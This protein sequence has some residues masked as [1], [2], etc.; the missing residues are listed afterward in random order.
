MT[1]RQRRH[2]S[3]APPARHRGHRRGQIRCQQAVC[4]Q[5]PQQRPQRRYQHLRR[6]GA[7]AAALGRHETADPGSGQVRQPA[8]I[9]SRGPVQEQPGLRHVMADRAGRQPPLPRQIG[10]V[11]A[12]Q[13]L[14]SR[15]RLSQGRQRHHAQP[16]KITQQQ[17]QRLRRQMPG[18]AGRAAISQEP[19]RHR[20]RQPGR[21]QP[22][23]RQPAA[24]MRHRKHLDARR[25]GRVTQP[26]QLSRKPRPI[27]PQRLGHPDTQGI[28]HD[29]SPL[30]NSDKRVW[31]TTPGLCR[32]P[33]HPP[34]RHQR[35]HRQVGIIPRSA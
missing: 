20:R 11:P 29:H 9:R 4:E 7:A 27:P 31:I 5:E 1:G 22:L 34:R 23:N 16:P 19:L 17:R 18:I 10:P 13:H 28:T 32:P 12:Q 24:Q 8:Q 30:R 3:G 33:R 25:A 35:L 14:R 15:P 6:P 21:L 26:G 2:Q